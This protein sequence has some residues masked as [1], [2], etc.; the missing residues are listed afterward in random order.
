M[1]CQLTVERF[2][3]EFCV[4]CSLVYF[5][6]LVGI[7]SG[8]A[9]LLASVTSEPP[10]RWITLIPDTSFLLDLVYFQKV[11]CDFDV[12]RNTINNFAWFQEVIDICVVFFSP[13]L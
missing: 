8:P 10:G 9:A 6:T 5:N 3:G 12:T 13:L 1:R 2:Y 7:S 4:V 11:F